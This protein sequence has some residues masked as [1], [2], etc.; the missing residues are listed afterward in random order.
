MVYNK[1][2]AYTFVDE[3]SETV[4][5]DLNDIK[6][7]WVARENHSA[8]FIS[9]VQKINT[10]ELREKLT[11]MVKVRHFQIYPNTKPPLNSSENSTEG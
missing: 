3:N 4:H 11:E 10:S 7:L 5:P 2:D 8:V 9:A 1:I 6:N